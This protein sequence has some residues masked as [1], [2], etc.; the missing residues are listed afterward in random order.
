MFKSSFKHI[1]SLDC[2]NQT[3]FRALNEALIL[4]HTR[5][6]TWSRVCA[7][8]TA[9]K[10]AAMGPIRDLP[11]SALTHVPATALRPIATKDFAAAMRIIK[12]STDRAMLASYEEFT[13]AFG[14]GG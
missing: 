11:P 3:E 8:R 6:F 5:S 7:L 2:L 12:P 13:R 14:T 10:E 1:K 4:T 9:A